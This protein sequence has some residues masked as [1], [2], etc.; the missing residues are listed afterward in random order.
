MAVFKRGDIVVPLYGMFKGKEAMVLKVLANGK[1]YIQYG[2]S[3]Y[4]IRKAA[5]LKLVRRGTGENK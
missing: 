1:V 4:A 3:H 2:R 5:N